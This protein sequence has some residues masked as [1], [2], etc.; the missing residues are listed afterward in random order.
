MP[1]TT[2]YADVEVTYRNGTKIYYDN[3]ELMDD[4]S[5]EYTSEQFPDTVRLENGD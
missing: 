4:D 3:G 5:W 2:G 1:F